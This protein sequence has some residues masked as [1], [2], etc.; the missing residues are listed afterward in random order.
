MVGTIYHSP[1]ITMPFRDVSATSLPGGDQNVAGQDTSRQFLAIENTGNANLGV[2]FSGPASGGTG[3]AGVGNTAAIGSTGTMTLV[4]NGSLLFDR[5]VPQ[6]PVNLNGTSGQP[7][8]VI[9]A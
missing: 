5:V 2:N 9:V 4:P 7:V 1:Q 8:T 3:P 6:N